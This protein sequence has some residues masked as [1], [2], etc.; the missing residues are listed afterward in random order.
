[1]LKKLKFKPQE[2]NQS[3]LVPSSSTCPFDGMSIIGHVGKSRKIKP[4]KALLLS[5][6]IPSS[7]KHYIIRSFTNTCKT[8]KCTICIKITANCNVVISRFF[9]SELKFVR[10]EKS[11]IRFL[12]CHMRH[13]FR[14]GMPFLPL[15]MLPSPLRTM[16]LSKL[17][18]LL[19]INIG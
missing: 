10:D 4:I 17:L 9:S 11:H 1:M 16:A 14:S 6:C 3:S 15:L 2:A 13:A 12:T 5:M 18:V 8:F 7:C 19:S